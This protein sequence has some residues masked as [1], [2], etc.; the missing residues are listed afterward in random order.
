MDGCQASPFTVPEQTPL[1]CFM[2]VNAV[3]II[4]V[5]S[6]KD[7]ESLA[8][9]SSVVQ[10]EV[11]ELLRDEISPHCFFD[12]LCTNRCLLDSLTTKIGHTCGTF[13]ILIYGP[14]D[15]KVGV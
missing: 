4:C 11:N 15:Q 13:R 5:T 12:L 14:D 8:E 10:D 3:M 7:E 2:R 6:V 9:V 1:S